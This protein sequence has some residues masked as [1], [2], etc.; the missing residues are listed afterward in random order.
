M[1]VKSRGSFQQKPARVDVMSGKEPH[2]FVG[3]RRNAIHQNSPPGRSALKQW[4]ELQEER[5]R[6][7]AHYGATILDLKMGLEA[8]IRRAEEISATFA[9]FKRQVGAA[10][11]AADGGGGGRRAHRGRFSE[12]PGP[13]HGRAAEGEVPVFCTH[14]RPD[15]PPDSQTRAR[16]R[17]PWRRG[18]LGRG[19]RWGRPP[20]RRSSRGVSPSP[21]TRPARPARFSLGGRERVPLQLGG[22]RPRRN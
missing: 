10:A 2:P 6:A 7:A 1:V 14:L 5:R 15:P 8:R 12:T 18:S 17:W 4:G 3:G 19:A 21:G 13:Q 16:D 11:G 20:W 22:A 9:D